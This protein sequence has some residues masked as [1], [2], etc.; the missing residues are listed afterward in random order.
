MHQGLE[1]CRDALE[2]MVGGV[3]ESDRA[4]FLELFAGCA[5]MTEEFV[6]AGYSVLKLRD[7]LLGHDLLTGDAQED[8]RH[9]V[10]HGRP[11]MVWIALPCTL[12]R[13]VHADLHPDEVLA[14]LL[15]PET[16]AV[17]QSK[18]ALQHLD[19]RLTRHSR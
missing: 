15:P 10:L 7:I 18:D 14:Q 1:G 19:Q 8:V 11:R 16:G 17:A 5:R 6:R 4:D 13:A 9:D 2:A 12:K 3:E